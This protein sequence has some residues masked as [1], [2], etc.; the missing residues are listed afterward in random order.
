MLLAVEGGGFFS[1]SASGY[2]KGLTLLL[3][4]QKD[5]H[6]KDVRDSRW[7]QYHLV[8]QEPEIHFQ[9][10][11]KRKWFSQMLF[12]CP[13][14]G[15]DASS[16]PEVGGAYQQEIWPGSLVPDECKDIR[17]DLIDATDHKM[18]APRS[19]LKRRSNSASVPVLDAH[20]HE[21]LIESV[22]HIPGGRR[23]Q[24]TDAVGTEL[25]EIREF[26]PSEIGESDNESDSKSKRGCTCT[27]M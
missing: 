20:E 22:N 23:V 19:T 10:H 9:P 5:K 8:N 26:E 1:S 17:A 24:W 4:G 21:S 12:R 13:S 2:R 7:N 6:D 15:A 14:G 25:V 3:L 16:S 11:L 27:I 18:C